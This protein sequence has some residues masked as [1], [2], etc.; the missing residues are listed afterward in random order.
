M[1]TSPRSGREASNVSAGRF[2]RIN[3]FAGTSIA[4]LNRHSLGANAST[5][6]ANKNAAIKNLRST[7]SAGEPSIEISLG[8][9]LRKTKKALVEKR[10][11]DGDDCDDDERDD[12]IELIEL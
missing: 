11:E 5:D 1:R 3:P 4:W 7:C 6:L 2:I 10:R 12:S 8:L 9:L